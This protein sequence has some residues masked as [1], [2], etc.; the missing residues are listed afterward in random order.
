MSRRK[1]MAIVIGAVIVSVMTTAV[2]VNGI[3]RAGGV[4]PYLL[5]VCN[6]IVGRVNE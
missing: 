4:K 6:A 5:T 1:T 2:T 3:Q